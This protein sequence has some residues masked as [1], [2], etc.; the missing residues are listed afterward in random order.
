MKIKCFPIVLILFIAQFVNGQSSVLTGKIIDS[1]N[2]N[3]IQGA[4]VFISFN[5]FTYTNG[6]GEYRID[7]LSQ[8]LHEIKISC[9]GYKPLST[10]I[11]IDSTSLQKDFQLEPS[12]I[13]LDE[14]VVST[15][16][17]ENY[18]RN[19]PFAE[20][21]IDNDEIQ[22]RPAVSLADIL[23]NEPG[24]SLVRD[25]I[26]GTELNIRGLSRENIVTL[27]NGNRIVTSTDI[28]ARLSM[29]DLNDIDRV[30]VIKGASSSIYGSGATGGIV[31]IITKSPQFYN[32]FSLNGNVSGEYNTVNDLSI[33]SGSFLGGS[34]VW[35]AK[36]SGS[37]RN[38]KNI[39]TPIGE[40]K[41]SQFEDY[42][43]SGAL[44]IYPFDNHKLI[45][46]YQLFRADN[47]G[48][49]GASVFP[50]N[51]DVRYPFERRQLISAGY[52][53]QN[54]SKTFYK[55]SAKYSY[56]LINR[57][58]ENIPHTVQNIPA[59][60]NNPARRISVLK[61]TPGAD[62][63]NNNAQLQGNFWLFDDHNL[64]AGLDYW[65][66]SYNGERE[67]YQLIEILDSNGNVVNTTNRVVGEKPIPNS[68]YSSLGIFAQ[69]EFKL[70][71]DKLSTTIGLRYD[72]INISAEET[73]NPLYVITNGNLD[74]TPPSQEV[75][76]ESTEANNSSYSG[77]LGFIY[78][79]F[80]DLD[81]TLGL[82][83]SFR[84]PSLEERFQY[85]DQGSVVRVGNPELNPEKGLTT[86]FGIRYYSN[87]LKIISNVFYS[88]YNDLVTEVPGTF[89]G[90]NALIKTNIGE[91]RIY[92]FDFRTDYNFWK[93]FIFYSTIS[94]V[95]GDDLTNNGY[96]PQIP[97]P[98]G[99]FGFKFGLFDYLNTDIYL[100][101]FAEQ[102]DVA[103]GEIATPG[104]AVFNF[105]LNTVPIKFSSIS[106]RIY[107]GIENIFDKSY[108]NHLSTTRGSITIEPGRNIFVK[109][110]VEF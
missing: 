44:N 91:A 25:G 43:F 79:V 33:F 62:H 65:D 94:Y 13:E 7:G 26:W 21:V 56:Q 53:I 61:I 64:V 72:Y 97:A 99:N 10:Q 18:L 95:K 77:N 85:I 6:N 52:D 38:A 42:T 24:I 75:L 89:D 19:S 31:N 28:A 96:L 35:S 17:T 16:R 29:I 105:L 57:D 71:D 108:R 76:W 30:E 14:V 66:R 104:Y 101:L 54:I 55:L 70:F 45:L 80:T 81:L 3:N 51:A 47:V 83:S 41:N 92:G 4:S 27:I 107:S 39:Q 88:Y 102:N 8:G 46:D 63:K 86:D 60:G 84:S 90:R 22:K 59:S 20:L 9:L 48:V 37:Y 12:L 109:L 110:A 68:K 32:K 11:K 87:N 34:S 98:N 73:L 106:F 67:R 103:E 5:Y 69:D 40:L 100:T 78:S 15:N 2:E 74:T 49:P 82:G 1:K 50:D 36:I 93:D 58:V 23:Q